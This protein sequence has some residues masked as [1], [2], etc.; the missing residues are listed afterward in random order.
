[1]INPEALTVAET[2]E[3]KRKR[4][5]RRRPDPTYLRELARV[6]NDNPDAPAKA[7][8]AW[9]GIAPATASRHIA[10]ARDEKDPKT[11]K[12]YLTTPK[13]TR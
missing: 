9:A 5:N 11:R 4:A 8:E 7:V 3:R 1:M 12:P 2:A 13:A 6:F 10:K